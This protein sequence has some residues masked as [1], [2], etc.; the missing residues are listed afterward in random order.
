M[1]YILRK[2]LKMLPYEGYTC[3]SHRARKTQTVLLEIRIALQHRC[4]LKSMAERTLF[5]QNFVFLKMSE[6]SES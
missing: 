6:Y 1:R 5:L 2:P 3:Q 4:K